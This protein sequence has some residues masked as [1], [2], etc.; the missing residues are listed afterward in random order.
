MFFYF[1]EAGHHA[2]NL[3]DPN[4]YFQSNIIN[5]LLLA[6]LI[7]WGWSKAVPAALAKR[8]RT[9]EDTLAGAANAREEAQTQ[10]NEQM[11]K[12]EDA[13]AE[14][15]KI[16]DEAKAVAERMKADIE[17]QTRKEIAQMEEKFEAAIASERHLVITQMRQAAVRAAIELSSEYLKN[18]ITEADQKLLLSQFM[19]QL[20]SVSG[21]E[22]ISPGSNPVGSIR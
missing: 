22:A 1:A 20:D 3:A 7:Y 6:F 12:I 4:F 16:I 21:S 14:A 10:L 5:W 2:A 13:Q 15:E 18:N 8:A 9:I 11:R 17:E 19:E